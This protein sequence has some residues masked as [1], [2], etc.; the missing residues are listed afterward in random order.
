M[1]K[2]LLL[3]DIINLK[4][5]GKLYIFIIAIWLAIAIAS[6]D[7]NF[8][9]GVM[10]MFTILVPISAAAYDDK[11]KWDRFALTMPIS[12][13]DLVLSK[14]LLALI[15]SVVTAFLSEIVMVIITGDIL[16]SLLQSAA[17][18]MAGMFLVS[19][20]LPFIFKFGVEKARLI[21][22]A[23][24][25]IPTVLITAISGMDISLP[26]WKEPEKIVWLFPVAAITILSVSVAVSKKIY[27]NKEL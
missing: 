11:A 2:G 8:F 23:V 18:V 20:I 16:S 14:Y 17:Y 10:T 27:D 12:R 1:M 6:R 19:L 13:W 7:G 26:E 24:V 3:K 4:Q 15:C 22:M 25:L 21:M 9:G 5:Q